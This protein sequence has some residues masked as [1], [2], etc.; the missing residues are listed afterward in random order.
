MGDTKWQKKFG[1]QYREQKSK[2]NKKM[3]GKTAR[4]RKKAPAFK[5]EPKG[6]KTAKKT[7]RR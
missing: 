4:E 2:Y 5:F 3:A 7:S 6:K 1:K